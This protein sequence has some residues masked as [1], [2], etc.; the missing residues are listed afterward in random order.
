M[1]D[2]EKIEKALEFLNKTLHENMVKLSSGWNEV[3]SKQ[4]AVM[5]KIKEI[6][7]EED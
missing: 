4:N 1:N 2:K 5:K 6:L 7:E 3:Y